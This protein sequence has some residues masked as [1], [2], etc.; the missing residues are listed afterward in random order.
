MN[1]VNNPSF[2]N[3]LNAP[4]KMSDFKTALK[5]ISKSVSTFDLEAYTKWTN[6][7]KSN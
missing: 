1:L 7:F 6:E 2:T 3:D 4:I 5:N